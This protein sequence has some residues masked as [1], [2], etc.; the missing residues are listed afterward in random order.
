MC[1]NAVM[2]IYAHALGSVWDCCKTMKMC[3]KAITA[4]LSAI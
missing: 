3:I 4:C 1:V 2:L